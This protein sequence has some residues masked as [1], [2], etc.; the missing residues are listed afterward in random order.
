MGIQ[1]V[2]CCLIYRM[3]VGEREG[4]KRK[5]E[6]TGRRGTEGAGL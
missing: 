6:A 2:V 4:L 3:H 5:S 1:L